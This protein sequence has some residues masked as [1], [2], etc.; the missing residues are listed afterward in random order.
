MK[1]N[2]PRGYA[3]FTHVSLLNDLPIPALKRSYR[4]SD[5]FALPIYYFRFREF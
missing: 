5:G 2:Q 4:F 3:Y 1:K